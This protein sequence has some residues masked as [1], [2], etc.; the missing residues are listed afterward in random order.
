MKKIIILS[1]M[2][3]LSFTLVGCNNNSSSNNGNKEN[4]ITCK[5]SRDWSSTEY[6]DLSIEMIFDFNAND[7]LIR[8]NE[9]QTFDNSHTIRDIPS[10]TQ[11]I[12]EKIEEIKYIKVDVNINKS[13]K[14]MFYNYIIDINSIKNDL[15]EGIISPDFYKELE[16]PYYSMFPIATLEPKIL[17]EYIY[18]NKET[19]KVKLITD[20]NFNC[21]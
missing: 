7:E 14:D 6:K 11:Q 16:Y 13:N 17:K 5:W 15:N 18:Y 2:M 8:V 12:K 3:L 19:L 20:F 9:N 10:N 1:L 21:K 4:T